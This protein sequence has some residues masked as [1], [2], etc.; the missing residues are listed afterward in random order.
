MYL[1]GC[2]CRESR[3]TLKLASGE[4]NRTFLQLD[5][6]AMST[7]VEQWNL[8]GRSCGDGYQFTIWSSELSSVGSRT[9]SLQCSTFRG[10]GLTYLIVSSVVTKA[11]K[12][13]D[14]S[15]NR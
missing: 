8:E 9:L 5:E 2:I 4:R 7:Q 6:W 12:L 1:K 13:V 3:N 14:F 11:K 15:N 10:R